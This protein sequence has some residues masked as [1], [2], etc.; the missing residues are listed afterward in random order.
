MLYTFSLIVCEFIAYEQHVNHLNEREINSRAAATTV[1]N[2][3]T[4][5]ISPMFQVCI[6]HALYYNE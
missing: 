6:Y 1:R 5:D 3:M 4:G 2:D